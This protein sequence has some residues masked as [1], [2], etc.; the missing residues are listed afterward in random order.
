MMPFHF[1]A[2]FLDLPPGALAGAA[3]SLTVPKLARRVPLFS[4]E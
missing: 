2:L 1:L 3:L 4:S